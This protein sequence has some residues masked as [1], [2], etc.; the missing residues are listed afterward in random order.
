[1]PI[2]EGKYCAQTQLYY[3]NALA[4]GYTRGLAK[5]VSYPQDDKH[6]HQ[7]HS[8]P[9]EGTVL[10]YFVLQQVK[11]RTIRIFDHREY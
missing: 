4:Q 10:S 9:L 3:Y 6:R 11:D 1:M 2:V 5:L 7:H 8:M